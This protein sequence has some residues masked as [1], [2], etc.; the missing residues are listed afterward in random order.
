MIGDVLADKIRQYR[1]A[2]AVDQENVLQ[3]LMQL[4]V[5]ASLA[6]AGFFRQAGFHG[7][8]CLRIVHALDRFSEDLDFLLKRPDPGFAWRGFLDAVVRD[9]AGEGIRLHILDKSAADS[10]VRKA[11][12]KTDSI[13]KL[14]LL[15]LPFAR[16]STRKIR[17]K[18]EIDTN[19]PAGSEFETAYITFPAVAA[20]TVQTLESSFATKSHALLC[21]A[22]TKGRDWYDFL[23]YASRGIRPNLPL[24]ERAV[25]QQ[26]PW[27]GRGVKVSGP[28]YL[29][30]MRATI[31]G[32]DWPAA[33]ED[34][35][36][37]LRPRQQEG[38]GLWN[39]DLFLYHLDKL[40]RVFD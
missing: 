2:D 31:A 28:W 11:F 8:S 16:R 29:D 26:G 30:R 24:L 33:A 14:L 20:I 37:F 5:L 13:G 34:V 32:I 17:I 19:P 12:L 36:R 25:D 15:D 23:W 10:A 4:F 9:C 27:A 38:L 3:E 6:R 35:R 39:A 21:C 1:P 22:Y 7:G 40:G 18:L